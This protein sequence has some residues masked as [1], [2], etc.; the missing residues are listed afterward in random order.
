MGGLQNIMIY[1]FILAIW[2]VFGLALNKGNTWITAYLNL[3]FNN[4]AAANIGNT[5]GLQPSTVAGS[6]YLSLHTADPGAGGNQSTS[7]T[8]YTNY[9]RQAVARSSSGFTVSGQSTTLTSAVNF[10]AGATTD[11]DVLMFFGVG[12][13]SSGAG[14]LLYSGVLGSNLGIGVGLNGNNITIP[15]SSL[16]VGN[17]VVFAVPTGGTIPTGLTA[18][19][20]YYVKTASTDTITVSTTSGGSVV[21]ISADGQVLA[22]QVTPITMGGGIV[23]T[24]QLPTSTTIT[25]K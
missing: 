20:V 19:T 23:V 8:V 15:G 10:P 14:E 22:Y 24:P 4:V 7:E 1:L 13:A 17:R 25:E 3:L 12:T 5:G 16:A 18:G 2:L 6:L 21:A 9:T 11:T